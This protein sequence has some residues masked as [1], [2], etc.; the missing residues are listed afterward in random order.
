[1]IWLIA[2]PSCLL[3]ESYCADNSGDTFNEMLPV[4]YENNR[5][6]GEQVGNSIHKFKQK[7]FE[8]GDNPERR[9]EGS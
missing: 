5:M 7:H 3:E 6:I 2:R 8:L 9:L 1:M 4:K